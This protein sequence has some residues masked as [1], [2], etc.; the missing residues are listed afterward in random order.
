[1]LQSANIIETTKATIKSLENIISS[2]YAL[3]QSYEGYK[4]TSQKEDFTFKYIYQYQKALICLLR[5]LPMSKYFLHTE[6]NPINLSTTA[7]LT[8]NLC[9]ILV[10]FVFQIVDNETKDDFNFKIL[11]QHYLAESKRLQILCKMNPKSEH[12]LDLKKEVALAEANLTKV[13]RFKNLE[14]KVKSDILKNNRFSPHSSKLLSKIG[15]PSEFYSAFHNYLS[16]HT[17]YY[18]FAF[19]QDIKF[20]YKNIE[21]QIA[22]N[23]VLEY[24]EIVTCYF[25]D[26]IK[27]EI[28][29]AE[30]F[31]TA[32]NNRILYWKDYMINKRYRS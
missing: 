19:S 6:L 24:A 14:N 21:S 11:L 10:G 8:R 7:S 3:L 27:R 31:W 25:L 23:N 18:A 22:F 28:R 26:S 17:H 12:I 29:G 32:S 13:A 5:I 4:P 15:I 20:S 1:M 2:F 30:L 9:D 16:N